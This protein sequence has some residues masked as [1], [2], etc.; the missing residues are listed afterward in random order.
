M[1]AHEDEEMLMQTVTPP[2]S[3]LPEKA[4][5]ELPAWPLGTALPCLQHRD[6]GGTSSTKNSHSLAKFWAGFGANLAKS[7]GTRGEN[8]KT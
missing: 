4:P 7:T 5:A 3:V 2:V 6:T 8:R 1:T